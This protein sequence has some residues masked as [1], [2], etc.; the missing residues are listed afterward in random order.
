MNEIIVG[1]DL[2]TTNSEIAVIVDGQ[3]KLLADGEKKIIPS[4]VGL[5]DD[6]AILVGEAARNQ[7]ALYPER[8]IKSVKRLMGKDES[9]VLG[10][11]S[12]SPQEVSAMIL[13]RLKQLAEQELGQPVKKAVITV[14]AYF[15]DIQ[16]QAT[17][18]A[19]EIAGLDV[20]RMINEPTAAVLT[21]EA[22]NTDPKRVVVYD[23]GGGTFDVS[24]VN[25]EKDV[26]EVIASHGNNQLG[27][28]D[29][30]EKIVAHIS[31]HLKNTHDINIQDTQ[32][33][34][35]RVRD[36][37]ENVKKTLSDQ[38]VVR[39]EEEFIAEKEGA[40][41][42]LSM[43][44]TRNEYEEMITPYID[45]TLEALHLALKDAGLTVSDIDEILLVGGATRTP[46]I[47]QRLEED[48]GLLPRGELHP[49]LCVAM[50]AAI[51]A[52]AIGGETVGTV[53]VDITP[54]TFGT[55][56]FGEM[57]GM[58]YPHVFTP[59]IRRNTPIPSTKS[60]LFSTMHDNQKMVEVKIYQGESPDALNNIEIGSFNVEGL[61]KAPA[62]NPIL[63]T[64]NLDLNGL[65]RVTA[66]ENDTGLEKSISIERAMGKFQDE[67][68]L[69]LAHQRIDS[70][71]D[72]LPTSGE[73]NAPSQHAITQ[74]R[75]LINKAES[76]FD[77][78][79][80]EDKEDMINLIEEINDNLNDNNITGLTNPVGQ[81]S[82]ILHYVEA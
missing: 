17:R 3:P 20:V 5:A 58:A 14:P 80:T 51:Q 74:A 71:F 32:K 27:G 41:V 63:L 13:K 46:L 2:G 69:S 15:S 21:Y 42:H 38:A 8:T 53:L 67:D 18:E 33:T 7:Y 11:H 22:G 10:D 6:G 37:A 24:V 30:D 76:V 48:L 79:S 66:K 43:E 16:R 44:L 78:V 81:L 4:V 19:G 47:S 28:D 35:A 59:I 52:G 40:P 12:Y 62:G 25:L 34:L 60:E 64:L 29:F 75:D 72:E 61:S 82:D 68:Q 9:I 54:Y 55:S 56:A 36:A 50:G 45:E 26:V 73:S 77:K 65:L 49:D 57:D 1:I 39:I 23:L 70:L 31:E